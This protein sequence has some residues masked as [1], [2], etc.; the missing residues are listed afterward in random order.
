MTATGSEA[1]VVEGTNSMTVTDSTLIGAV[2]RG[3]MLYNSISGDASAGIG[4]F[5]MNGGALTAEAGPV[6][7]VT[8]TTGIIHLKG[9][10]VSGASG[11]LVRVGNA[12]TGSGN[13]GAGKATFTADHETLTGDLITGWTGTITASLMH[14]KLTSSINKA[15]LT[16]DT[17]SVWTM[18]GNSTL[19]SSGDPSAVSA[20]TITNII[21]NGHTV[22][23]DPSLSGNKW[24]A[25]EAYA[26]TGG[27]KLAPA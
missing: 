9:V 12:D 17:A 16:L 8:N 21:G 3:V 15:G 7:Y 4:R 13:T 23:Y 11:T 10:Q 22:T 27:G 5:T 14:S 1:A 26:L 20:H 2:E 19:I 25:G 24:L 18:T 6:F